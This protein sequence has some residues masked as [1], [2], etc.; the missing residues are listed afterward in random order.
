M[1]KLVLTPK[2]NY[3]SLEES[4]LQLFGIKTDEDIEFH[5]QMQARFN[6]ERQKEN[7]S[8]ALFEKIENEVKD[9]VKR[10]NL[11]DYFKD[12]SSRSIGFKAEVSSLLAAPLEK[13]DRLTLMR[14]IT[15]DL[16]DA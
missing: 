13:E 14:I 7:E 11:E 6:E 5:N 8:I 16:A 12:I 9:I 4:G 2:G 10:N 3:V 1:T 15:K